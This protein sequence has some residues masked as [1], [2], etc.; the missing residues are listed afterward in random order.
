MLEKLLKSRKFVAG[1]I[2]VLGVVLVNVLN[3]EAELAEKLSTTIVTMAALFIGGTALEDAG[4]K[5]LG[6]SKNGDEKGKK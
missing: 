1:L 6:G 5:L 3:V 4:E 2:A